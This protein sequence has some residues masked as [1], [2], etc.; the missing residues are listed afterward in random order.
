MTS[1]SIRA[2]EHEEV[3]ESIQRRAVVC[4]RTA[5]L[6][7]V[8]FDGFSFASNNIHVGDELVGLEACC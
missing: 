7:P 2:Q 5:V 6:A 3:W 4:R 8:L 1:R